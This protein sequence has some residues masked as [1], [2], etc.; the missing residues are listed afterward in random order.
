MTRGSRKSSGEEDGEG[1]NER[2]STKSC[3]RHDKG[4][5]KRN[6][7]AMGITAPESEEKSVA[8]GTGAVINSGFDHHHNKREAKRS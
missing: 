1:G 3:G 8:T 6:A 7:D 4:G 5:R 2:C